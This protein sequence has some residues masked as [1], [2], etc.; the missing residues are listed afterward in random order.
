M[1]SECKKASKISVSHSLHQFIY[2]V[3]RTSKRWL[4]GC[5]G[6]LDA[7]WEAFLL[8]IE[9]EITLAL[10]AWHLEGHPTSS[11]FGLL[12]LTLRICMS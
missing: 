2:R 3:S 6:S 8:V 7:K 12:I 10:M 11:T 4:V 9:S 5:V 1:P